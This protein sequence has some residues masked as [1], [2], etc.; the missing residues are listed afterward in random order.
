MGGQRW[1]PSDWDNHST[2]TRHQTQQQIFRQSSIHPDLDPLN[3]KVR[4]SVDS[5]AN[6]QST[7]V[8]LAVDETGSMGHLAEV[9]IKT[10]LGVIMG[11]IYNRKPIHDPHVLCIAVGDSKVDAAPLQATQFEASIVL[12]EQVKNF[13][14]E[15]NGGGNHGES[16]HLVW[17]FAAHKTHCDSQLKRGRK[18]YIFTIGDEPPHLSLGK[19]EI[20]RVFGDDVEADIS[21]RDLLD[22]VS[23][24]WEVFHLIVNPGAYDKTRWVELL[25]ERA[26]DVRD[27]DKLAE[28]IV[29][30]MQ[31][32]EGE[33][34]D[35]VAGS[36]SGDTSL[37]V[38]DAIGGLTK[39]GGSAGV[40]QL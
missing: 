1:S 5:E 9:I 2:Q 25:G 15:G 16:Y 38:R 34:V 40:V 7:P 14:L 29:S 4:E 27:H 33:D 23:Q 20:K 26:I 11:E 31:V 35:A 19:D 37:V 22:L 13:Y 10:G 32:I 6:P 18:G 30:T 28:V 36:W 21:S 39:A 17:Y 3:I 24:N 12:A 8:I